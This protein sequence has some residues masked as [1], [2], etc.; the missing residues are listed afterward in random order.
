VAKVPWP[1]RRLARRRG[2]SAGSVCGRPFF[3]RVLVQL[4]GLG[5][6][7]AQGVAV[8]PHPGLLLEAVPQVQ[9]LHPVAA[10]F[11]GQLGG[12]DALGDAAEDQQDLRGPA[13]RALQD[14][15]GPGVEDPMAPAALVVQDGLAVAAMD[16]EMVASTAA[17]AGQALGVEQV[18]EL[19]VA[20]AF[21]EE[22]DQGEVQ[23]GDSGDPRGNHLDDTT[24][25]GERQEA[26]HQPGL[27]SQILVLSRK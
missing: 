17:G 16:A 5:A 6:R 12:G 11:A 19:G 4:V 2:G 26:G 25:S 1:R 8:D 27:M 15:P 9:Q 13:L 23:G 14:R 7:I 20:R 22:V 10:Q 21:V 3:P 18:E 24:E